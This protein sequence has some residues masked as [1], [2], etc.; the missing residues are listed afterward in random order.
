MYTARDKIGH[1]LGHV[2]LTYKVTRQG[3]VS[4]IHAIEFP[5]PK[6]LE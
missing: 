5:D 4:G 2:T 1:L 3:Y 6:T